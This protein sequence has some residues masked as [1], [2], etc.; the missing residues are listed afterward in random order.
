DAPSLPEQSVLEEALTAWLDLLRKEAARHTDEHPLWNH[1]AQGFNTN[2]A[3]QTRE[4]F[5]QGFRSFQ[6]GQADEM[7]RT[8]RAIYEDLEK[9][10]TLLNTLRGGKLAVDVAAILGAVAA[11]AAGGHW[12]LDLI[13]VPLATSLTHQ[14]VELFGSGYVENQRHQAKQRQEALM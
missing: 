14:L 4:R 11:G 12:W 6:L 2:L 8:A 13:L 1:I 5:Q 7:D 9:N 3:Q 10:P